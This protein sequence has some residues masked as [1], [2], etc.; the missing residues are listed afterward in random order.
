LG[1]MSSAAT[2]REKKYEKGEDKKEKKW[3]GKRQ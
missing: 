1:G 3:I 2:I